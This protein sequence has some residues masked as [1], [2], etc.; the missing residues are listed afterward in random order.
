MTIFGT[1]YESF[2]SSLGY[3]PA[4]KTQEIAGSFVEKVTTR[5]LYSRSGA[6]M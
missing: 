4:D 5:V 2:Y 1:G 3:T 6:A